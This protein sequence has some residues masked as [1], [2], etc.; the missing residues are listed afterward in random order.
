MARDDGGPPIRKLVYW[1]AG[2]G[3]GVVGIGGLW[4]E[5]SGEAANPGPGYILS[6][7]AAFIFVIGLVV[8]AL[9]D[10]RHPPKE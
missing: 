4:L 8:S 5:W 3:C 7:V 1:I 6:A 2:W 10:E 9:D